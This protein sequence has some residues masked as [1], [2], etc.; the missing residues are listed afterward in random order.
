M[1]RRRFIALGSATL[2]AHRFG[3]NARAEPLR[4]GAAVVYESDR[5]SAERIGLLF[6]ALGG[7]TTLLHVDP[8]QG[9]VVV[10][11]NLC[12]PDPQA[13][14]TTTSMELL[15]HLCAYLVDAGVRKIIIADHTLRKTSDFQALDHFALAKKYAEVKVILANEERYFEPVEVAGKA[16]KKTEILKL[17][18]RADLLINVPTAKHHSASHVSLGLKN[19]MGCIWNRSSFHTDMDLSQAVGD[20]ALAVRPALTIVD[21]SRVLLDGGPT[22]PGPTITENRFF[23]STDILAVDATVTERYNFGGKKL[24]AAAVPHLAAAHNNGVGE[25][26]PARISLRRL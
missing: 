2:L 3:L 15:D 8:G 25:I 1:D 5:L 19:L 10:K 7:M 14:A 9:T 4:T 18:Q 16:L 20:L 12:L 6:E 13:R 23:A 22:G 11:P 24:P 21:A 26:D 17:V